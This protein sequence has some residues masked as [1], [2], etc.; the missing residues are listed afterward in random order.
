MGQSSKDD[1]DSLNDYFAEICTATNYREPI[2]S[3][4]TQ[5][6]T[7]SFNLNQI[8]EGLKRIRKTACGPDEIPFWVWSEHAHSLAEPVMNIPYPQRQKTIRSFRLPPS[9]HHSSYFPVF[10]E[11]DDELLRIKTVQ[12]LS[13][14]KPTWF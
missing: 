5:K 2:V 4:T 8:Y 14:Q 11:N 13:A 3:D 1:P 9:L 12:Q 6:E 7:P 10:R